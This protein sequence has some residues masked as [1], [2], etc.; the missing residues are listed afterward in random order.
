MVASA[1]K[2]EKITVF[3]VD[4]QG[5]FRQGVKLALNQ[6]PDIEV[7][8]EADLSDEVPEL[9]QTFSP[10]IALMDANPPFLDGLDLAR[11]ITQRCPTVSVIAL[12]SHEDDDEFFQ[13][14]RSGA[15]AYLG[16]RASAEEL[17]EAIRRVHRGE[18]PINDS[19][20]ARPRVAQQVLRQF[21]SLSLMGKRAESLAAPLSPRELEILTY[22]AQGFQN[23]QIA[24]T[25]AISEQTIKNHITSILRKLDANDR[26]H[27]VV[28]AIRQGWISV[29]GKPK[30]PQSKPSQENM[31]YST[32][33]PGK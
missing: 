23:K 25:L 11:R 19:L 22:I 3:L 12:T 15:A 20:L 4:S 32:G 33:N 2:M 31:E 29:E 8:G 6:T 7:V 16:K 18:Y 1:R 17:A 21:Q 24:H 10:H 30:T 14:I 27:A 13:A 28:L 5:L 9:I 26:T